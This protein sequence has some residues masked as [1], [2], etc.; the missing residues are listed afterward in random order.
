M[1][2][3][4]TVAAISTGAVAIVASIG[5]CLAP[6]FRK[7]KNS[8]AQND[9]QNNQDM[10]HVVYDGGNDSECSC[11]VISWKKKTPPSVSFISKESDLNSQNAEAIRLA[12]GYQNFTST[13]P[14][15]ANTN[16]TSNPQTGNTP[17]PTSI[18]TTTA[19]DE[20]LLE[21]VDAQHFPQLIDKRD[22]FQAS[23]FKYNTSD[24][25]FSASSIII[26][27]NPPLNPNDPKNTHIGQDVGTLLLKPLQQAIYTLSHHALPAR[28]QDP[29]HD[30]H[31]NETTALLG[32]TPQSST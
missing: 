24:G 5:S 3:P 2:D 8:L 31:A 23:D 22:H 32:G 17:V 29:G 15:P 25:S 10:V 26:H 4:V 12:N 18:P 30:D 21:N 27:T 6:L 13:Q 11:W 20:V 16:T 19:R 7:Q 9:T 14:R 1:T 28:E